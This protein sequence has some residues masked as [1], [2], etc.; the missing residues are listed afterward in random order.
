MKSCGAA[1]RESVADASG[2]GDLRDG[3]AGAL[4]PTEYCSMR[5]GQVMAR[6]ADAG[7]N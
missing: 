1:G 5:H 2:T 4:C 6:T 7:P 3:G